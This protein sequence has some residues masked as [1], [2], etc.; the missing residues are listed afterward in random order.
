MVVLTLTTVGITNRYLS[1]FFAI[2]AVGVALGRSAILPLLDRRPVL[3][4]VTAIV[5]LL[6]ISWSVAVTFALNAR[7]VFR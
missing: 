5:S 1:D 7:L 4:A 2:S 3:T 6:L